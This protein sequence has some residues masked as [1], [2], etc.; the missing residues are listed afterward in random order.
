MKLPKR[1]RVRNP[2][3]LPDLFTWA[4]QQSRH[5]MPVL[6]IHLPRTV[7]IA[8]RHRLPVAIAAVFAE[9]MEARQ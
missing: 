9:A 2:N 5:S 4:D 6:A 1:S 7:T 3:L 8:R